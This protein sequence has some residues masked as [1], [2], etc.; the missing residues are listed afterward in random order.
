M[1]QSAFAASRSAFRVAYRIY[2]C[3]PRQAL[4]AITRAQKVEAVARKAEAAL[5]NLAT[6]A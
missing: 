4:E 3:Y 1:V 6:L 2:P 5:S